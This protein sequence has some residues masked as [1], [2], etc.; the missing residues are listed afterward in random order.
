M[1]EKWLIIL[2]VGMVMNRQLLFAVV[3]ALKERKVMVPS[4]AN[5]LICYKEVAPAAD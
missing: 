5:V 2:S 1:L 3:W 4:S